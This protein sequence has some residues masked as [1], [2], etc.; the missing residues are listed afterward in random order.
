MKSMQTANAR[1]ETITVSTRRCP[2]RSGNVHTYVLNGT[3]LRDVRVD[4]RWITV[5]ASTPVT[6]N[7]A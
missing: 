2:R 1:T 6:A 7:A 4:G 5:S 3:Q